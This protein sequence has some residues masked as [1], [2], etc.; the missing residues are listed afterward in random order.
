MLRFPLLPRQPSVS[1]SVD[2]TVADSTPLGVNPTYRSH[3]DLEQR[4][5]FAGDGG[6][7]AHIWRGPLRIEKD[8]YTKLSRSEDIGG[9]DTAPQFKVLDYDFKAICYSGGVWGILA[10]SSFLRVDGAAWRHML[11][12]LLLSLLTMVVV[13][14]LPEEY[15]SEAPAVS[16]LQARVTIMV[17]FVLGLFVS[18]CI[19]R[20]WNY[21]EALYYTGVQSIKLQI[22]T[23]LSQALLFEEARG[24]FAGE[25]PQAAARRGARTR[26][27]TP[28]VREESTAAAAAAVTESRWSASPASAAGRANVGTPAGT[29]SVLSGPFGGLLRLGLISTEEVRALQGKRGKAQVVWI[30]LGEYFR[31]LVRN[32]ELPSLDVQDVSRV[33]NHICLGRDAVSGVAML[34]HT[35]LPYAYVSLVAFLV[36]IFHGVIAVGCGYTAA[37]ALTSD[38][39]ALLISEMVQVVILPLTFQSLLDVCVSIDDPFGSD[40]LDFSFLDFHVRLADL[41]AAFTSKPPATIQQ[42]SPMCQDIDVPYT[43][44]PI[45][46]WFSGSRRSWTGTEDDNAND[47]L[48]LPSSR[49]M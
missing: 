30:W 10:K 33:Q 2:A 32:N 27:S 31:A 21:Q 26:E 5:G 19:T 16:S 18:T 6:L 34:L 28:A 11:V 1:P 29:P 3:P 48:R 23:V 39:Y 9:H 43:S 40:V 42:G 12:A 20:W 15:R 14:Y 7:A 17:T 25:Q 37:V 45:D 22:A 13:V 4:E 8:G 41:C 38:M 46:Q 36:H 44:M 24:V 47:C 49:L 35:P